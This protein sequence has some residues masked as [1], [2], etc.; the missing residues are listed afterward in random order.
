MATGEHPLPDYSFL[1]NQP[2][3]LPPR[4]I[5]ELASNERS[6]PSR[7]KNINRYVRDLSVF[8]KP[9]CNRKNKSLVK[10]SYTPGEHH[11]ESFASFF[12][13]FVDKLCKRTGHCYIFY[14]N[15]VLYNRVPLSNFFR[16]MRKFLSFGG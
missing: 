11:L 1:F 13:F 2:L 9:R 7:R 12:P 10:V 5:V 14:R 3:S 15:E 6:I 16:I 8:P 4:L